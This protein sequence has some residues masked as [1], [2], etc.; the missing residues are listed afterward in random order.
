[1]SQ[2]VTLNN[3]KSVVENK[4]SRLKSESS[5]IALEPRLMFDGAM[6]ATVDE[7]VEPHQTVA[8]EEMSS[9]PNA[10]RGK[11]SEPAL[12][13]HTKAMAQ[14]VTEEDSNT[15][16]ERSNAASQ[17]I[18]TGVPTLVISLE[19]TDLAYGE[20]TV[21]TFAFD[22]PVTGFTIEDIQVSNGIIADL[23][24]DPDNPLLYRA[25]FTASNAAPLSVG[26]QQVSSPGFTIAVPAGAVSDADGNSNQVTVTAQFALGIDTD[27]DG[28]LDSVDIDD[29]NDGIL[30][31]TEGTDDNDLDGVINSLDLDSDND[32]ITDNIEW[33]ST[34]GYIAPSGVDADGDGL[35][36]AYAHILVTPPTLHDT[37][38]R[39][40]SDYLDG[41]SDEDGIG[42]RVEGGLSLT[43]G[44]TDTDGDG[45]RDTYEGSDINDGY[46]V[47][48][49][50]SPGVIPTVE[51]DQNEYDFREVSSLLDFDAG[52][53]MLDFAGHYETNSVDREAVSLIDPD[54]GYS[55]NLEHD[56]YKVDIKTTGITDY[57]AGQS[58]PS[59]YIFDSKM[60]ADLQV[61]TSRTVSY[62]GVDYRV[63]Y[64][65]S[66]G[67]TIVRVD[68][69]KFDE[70]GLRAL[71]ERL[72]YEPESNFKPTSGDRT[73]AVTLLNSSDTPVS[74]TAIA[75]V[76]VI[77]TPKVVISMSD[78]NL[79]AGETATVT[80]TFDKSIS[81]FLLGDLTAENGTLSNLV[82][83]G[84][85]PLV[86]TATF[87]PDVD[88]DDSSNVITLAE[89]G[90]LDQDGIG[91]KATSGDNYTVA[92][93]IPDVTITVDD[94]ALSIGETATV[95]FTFD[96]AVTGFTLAD[97]SAENG[98]LSNLVQDGSNPLVYTATLT[99]NASVEDS[100][101]V[102]TVAASSVTDA[103][104]NTNAQSTSASYAIDT[105]RPDVTITVDDT[106][107]S[108]G[109][110]ATVTFTFDE[111]VTGFSLGDISAE[112]GTLSNLVQDGSNPL[113]YTATLTPTASVE[114]T[115]N[116]ITVAAS[117]VTDASGNAN[118]QATSAS[119]A[120]DT[121][122][123]GV[124]I[125]VD[126]TSLTD[127]ETATVTFTF[128]EAVTGFSLGDISAENGTLSN[129]VQD[130]S[131][132][133][134]YTATLTPTASVEDTS[135]V[136]TVAASS[137]TDASGNTNAQATSVSYAVDTDRPGVTITVDDTSLSI[138]ETTTVT[139]T[140]DEAV[141]GFTLADV[142]AENGTLSNLV[143]D[144]SNPLVYT[145]TLT[146]T[147][148]VEDTSNV[149]TV[150]ASSVTDA[151][152]N[153][154][155]QATSA[156]YAVD[157][158]RP[159]V[160]IT[161]DD[162]SLSIG[163]TTTVTFTFDEAVTGFT[164]ADVS[165]EN[166]TLSNLVQDGSN[167]L[168]YTATLTPTASVEDTSN[169]ITVAASSVTDA[170]GNANAQ[171]TS[172]SYAVDTDRPGVTITVDDTSL[173]IGETTTVTFTFD[174]AVTGFT[175]ADVSAENGTLSN[176]VQDGSNPLVYTATL[177]PTASVEDTSNV[178]TVAA[179]SVT[180]ASGNTN[181]Q[182][183]SA[184]YAVDTDRPDVTITVDDTALSIG[185]TTTVTFTFDEAVTGFTLADV[186]AEN[187]ALSN[188]VQDGSN[189]L[190]YTATLTPTASV[191]DTSNV[192]TVAASSV[193][194]A[195]GNTNA[196]AT[197]ASYAV[198]T[199]RPDVTI[200]VDDTALSIGETTTVTFTFDEAVTGFTL[201]DVS[202]EN[203]ALSNLVQ[204]GSN[205]L[206]Y[207]ATLT[208]TASVEDTSNVITVAA[209]SVTD[210]SGNTN[211]QATSA[212]YAIDTDRPGVTI[213][214][215]DTALSIGETTTV[216]FT[217]DEA[218]TGFTL[219]DV[220]AENGTLSNLVQDGSNP[221]VYTATLTPTASVEDTSNV[222][223]VAASSVTDASGNTN[224][225]ATS[226]SYAVDTDRPGVT[227][228]VDDTSLSIGETTTVTF[229]FDEAVTGFTLAD[230][231][232]ENGTL[233][234][235]VQDGSNPLV[236]TATLT[237][238]ASV[239]DTSNVITVAASSVT[240]A[241][242]NT[243][244]QATSASYAIDTDRPG[245]M[246]TMDDVSLSSGERSIVTI[247]FDEEVTGLTL[248]DLLAE[249]GVLSNLQQDPINSRVYTAIFTPDNHREETD[250]LIM[251]KAGS[252]W[253]ANNNQNGNSFGPTYSIDTLDPTAPRMETEITQDPTPLITGTTEPGTALSITV[254]GK[255]YT[256]QSGQVVIDNLGN[257]SLTI[258]EEHA[259]PDGTIPTYITAIDQAGNRET[260]QESFIVDSI[261]PTVLIAVENDLIGKGET[262]EITFTFDEVVSGFELSDIIVE[263]GSLSNLV[264]DPLNPLVYHASF[265]PDQDVQESEGIILVREGA[266]FDQ[267]GNDNDVAQSLTYLV[268]TIPPEGL[269]IV[270][271]LT[272]DNTPLITGKTEIGSEV[273]IRI[274]GES[275][276]S[277]DGDVVIDKDGNWRLR[278]PEDQKLSD[279]V[280]SI[281][282]IARDKVGNEAA[283]KGQIKVDTTA[284]NDPSVDELITRD[285]SPIVTGKAP[286]GTDVNVVIDGITYS[287][288]E[289]EVT[290]DEEGGW[291][292]DL[293]E[294]HSLDDGSCAVDVTAIDEAGNSSHHQDNIVID[295]QGPS[296]VIAL[297]KTDLKEGDQS[298]VTFTF[299][300]RPYGFSLDDIHTEGGSL[301]DLKATDDP[302]VFTATLSP[303]PKEVQQNS[304]LTIAA[305]SVEDALGN[306]IEE[307]S[308]DGYS[309]DAEEHTYLYEDY[310]K[311]NDLPPIDRSAY[312]WHH[313]SANL[314]SL[315]SDLSLVQES[316][317]YGNQLAQN[318]LIEIQF[319]QED[320]P[321]S[322][323]R[324]LIADI[325]FDKI[326][327]VKSVD[328]IKAEVMLSVD[329]G[330]RVGALIIEN[331]P[332][333][334]E[335]TFDQETGLL[336][337]VGVASLTD[338]EKI[339]QQVKF[340]GQMD[341]ISEKNY[342]LEIKI[343]T[344]DGDVY[345]GMKEKR[346]EEDAG[347]TSDVLSGALRQQESSHLQKVDHIVAIATA[348]IEDQTKRESIFPQEELVTLQ[349][350]RL[351]FSDQI[352]QSSNQF[353]FKRDLI[354]DKNQR[355]VA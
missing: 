229:T 190:V 239:E 85:N 343:T 341:L 94:T 107:L 41:D 216:T 334:I 245:V 181:A 278:L 347:Q 15:G 207:T 288:K 81:G 336:S 56:I 333:G 208:P 177:T 246:I 294:E 252:V 99:P 74:N 251:L 120:I 178:I 323:S 348:T 262:S 13:T 70:A 256:S 39:G 127:G 31:V 205:P 64:D 148:S 266:V 1:M 313:D 337:I 321:S 138:G 5:K 48:D 57:N 186:S 146:P 220:S 95:T 236:Y 285:R 104:G 174:E 47:N 143:Q 103:S 275:Y 206:V 18:D 7:Y 77:N 282:L 117:S 213:T 281:E 123:P 26:A 230:V 308:S 305:G 24:Q 197:S 128:D 112:N 36:D 33:Q 250:N 226:V 136:I 332:D 289:G 329:G 183:T 302:N 166:G 158:D 46:N 258:P 322:L 100:S 217:F 307:T 75:T 139:F 287:S 277:V 242:G 310:S 209:S 44:W 54:D 90:V 108:I 51:N 249:N 37:D 6:A 286:I 154:N 284:P 17:T 269:E 16:I 309:V 240:D 132:P 98:T 84:S 151:S 71:I 219:A 257:W 49:G 290:V 192:I 353:E 241:S 93:S 105:D 163:E 349:G 351:K 10:A 118:A 22:E 131:N 237:P 201:A 295:T 135:N 134:V 175:L 133:L 171:A 155:A 298:R 280:H 87:T 32:G 9:F 45:L 279:G 159:G 274:K 21:V 129:L 149:I 69:N 342:R 318:G 34:A 345:L 352:L 162:T 92:T 144:G 152:G 58:R 304:K 325:Q 354:L 97:V 231:S 61:A 91:N 60:P 11:V 311:W 283:V 212:S 170:S 303:E 27:G 340:E 316:N 182:A 235:L 271:Q 116:V 255:T 62:N 247:S 324:F 176:L 3:C 350:E 234:N 72:E 101:N 122:R 78:Q 253:D 198:D 184:S 82:Q 130:G 301:S 315:H 25:V 319:D 102:I 264:Q 140:F 109:E 106:A 142:S 211:A 185:E 276:H 121:D 203:G 193:T 137:V 218:V 115:S 29:D 200:T 165:A 20:S 164:L 63:E 89:G 179:S 12:L 188:L 79:L 195:S 297:E 189:P 244:A 73:F 227:I 173:S 150:A 35:D 43:H 210:A 273:S 113:V 320:K 59:L 312:L 167:P 145:A 2:S 296:V 110:T 292:V 331:V 66:E 317:G 161:V 160:T 330:G 8:L 124:T 344:I 119:Y 194:D 96:E 88:V 263:H 272:N 314:E 53:S 215:D 306:L 67:I 76:K 157:T 338:Y 299:D 28:V 335:V 225:Q 254:D 40:S 268:D 169:V 147:A 55:L 327:M 248:E 168:V 38:G 65:G 260:T 114:D 265:T 267:A 52:T 328:L 191:E 202:A 221:L 339:I 50:Q 270:D 86:Y 233:S 156:S 222:I 19:K 83:D 125:T 199:D 204:D 326:D 153:A 4:K 14:E 126:D 172:A 42:D 228:T 300:E 180:D 238:T 355:E 261:K 187:G 232:A 214:V 68:G 293:P 80:F 291:S 223:T 196:Q 30:D 346:L 23:E 224:A 141:S 259:L 243:N 111:A